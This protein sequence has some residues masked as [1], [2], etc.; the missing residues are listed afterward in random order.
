MRQSGQEGLLP[1]W[2]QVGEGQEE[3][4][5]QDILRQKTHLKPGSGG[6]QE[7]PRLEAGIWESGCTRDFVSVPRFPNKVWVPFCPGVQSF[8]CLMMVDNDYW[9]E[10]GGISPYPA[11]PYPAFL[12]FSGGHDDDAGVLLPC[13]L[14]EVIDCGIQAALAGDIG[15]R[16]LIRA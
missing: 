13:H 12:H 4:L 3:C 9:G 2:G 7:N 11:Q 10:G 16:V 5:L 8:F 14:P 6:G 15:L 1:G